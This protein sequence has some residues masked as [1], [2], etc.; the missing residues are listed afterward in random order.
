MQTVRLWDRKTRTCR[1]ILQLPSSPTAVH[2]LSDDITVVT[3]LS[4]CSVW[5]GARCLRA[6]RPNF[7][8]LPHIACT[9]VSDN[10]LFLAPHG[11]AAYI[12]HVYTACIPPGHTAYIARG[13]AAH[14]S[15]G[16]AAYIPHD[17]TAYV[18]IGHTACITRVTLLAF[19]IMILLTFPMVMLLTLVMVILLT[20]LMVTLHTFLMVILLTPL[21]AY[22]HDGINHPL[23]LFASTGH[24][25]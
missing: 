17:G 15:H 3:C 5:K 7:V 12:P 8:L 13:V 22:M 10:L 2:L 4:T 24:R 25:H 20:F 16:N 23:C 6:I 11:N 9:A 21:Y 19:L 1:H 14:N 18:P